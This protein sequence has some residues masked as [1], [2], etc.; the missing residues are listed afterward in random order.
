M[1]LLSHFSRHRRNY[2]SSL[3]A[4]G[5]PSN[6]SHLQAYQGFFALRPP[7]RC[8]ILSLTGD[9]F[10]QAFCSLVDI[11][12]NQKQNAGPEFSCN[13]ISHTAGILVGPR[14][15]GIHKGATCISE[16]WLD[17]SKNKSIGCFHPMLL[18]YILPAYFAKNRLLQR[19][20]GW[21]VRIAGFVAG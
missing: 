14:L 1:P 13:G 5:P 21:A 19:S 10:C 17:G 4:E 16:D 20:N 7:G 15:E 9:V 3:S 8:R 11:G 12:Q 2:Q 6:M 18:P